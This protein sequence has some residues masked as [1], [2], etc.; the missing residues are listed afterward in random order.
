MNTTRCINKKNNVHCSKRAKA[1]TKLYSSLLS[2]FGYLQSFLCTTNPT[3]LTLRCVSSKTAHGIESNRIKRCYYLLHHFPICRWPNLIY[4]SSFHSNSTERW[5]PRFSSCGK[6][7]YERH[8]WKWMKGRGEYAERKDAYSYAN[9]WWF[10]YFTF[11][12]S[13]CA[14]GYSE[15]N[16]GGSISEGSIAGIAIYTSSVENGMLQERLCIGDIQD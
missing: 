8:G 4:T 3:P 14:E 9:L 13:S 5:K 6:L 11:G 1:S 15:K 12:S 2:K 16:F 10:V 7:R